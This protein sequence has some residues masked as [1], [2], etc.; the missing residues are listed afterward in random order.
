MDIYRYLQTDHRML[1]AL[2]TQVADAQNG[3]E[4]SRRFRAFRHAMLLHAET[5]EATFYAALQGAGADRAEAE[6]EHA[7]MADTLALLHR[8]PSDSLAW[9]A[10]FGPFR[11]AF[12]RHMRE[13]ERLFAL[14]R[15]LL[16]IGQA[17]ALAR[18][19]ERLKTHSLRPAD[20]ATP[21]DI[22]FHV[23]YRTA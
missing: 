13:E 18:E 19:M 9:R 11:Q 1:E 6:N 20:S 16:N 8:L 5:E 14:G 2:L 23:S 10:L 4:R 12:L 21:A 15:R 17:A 7:A 3:Q 22:P